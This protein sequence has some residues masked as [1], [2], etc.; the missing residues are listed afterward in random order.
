MLSLSRS[1]SLLGAL[2][3]AAALLV[4]LETLA[5][6]VAV[7][8]VAVAQE[9]EAAA[10][11]AAAAPAGAGGSTEPKR[12]SYLVWFYKALG[13]RYVIV[14]LAL[15]FSLVALVVMNMLAIRRDSIA[16]NHLAESFEANLN[17]KKFQEAYELAKNDDSY[18]GQILA[19]GMA[20]LSSG[21]DAASEA[22]SQVAD[23]EG[24]KLDQKL[25]YISLI[26]TLAPMFGLL[27]TVDG[28]VASFQVIAS[29]STAPKPSELAEGIS[30]ALVT[31]L[32]GLWLAIPAIAAYN[33][34]KMRLSKLVFD[35]GVKI[36]NL[37]GRFQTAKK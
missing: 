33:I 14:F 30:M 32:V 37:M 12:E 23:E 29:S 10:P 9:E 28:M 15:S 20:K 25:A 22:M 7:P 24:M 11:A 31:T 26:G 4:A 13:I 27:G 36:D 2:L 16:P 17:E 1:R 35:A 34:L 18:M 5:P 3:A 19:A 6:W 8:N 21:Y